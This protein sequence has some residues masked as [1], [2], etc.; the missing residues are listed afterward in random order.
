MAV[1]L[2][3]IERRG[4]ERLNHLNPV[5]LEQAYERWVRP[6][7]A[8]VASVALRLADHMVRAGPARTW[9]ALIDLADWWLPCWDDDTRLVF[10]PRLGGRLGT[11]SGAELD[12]GGRLWGHVTELEP[13]RRRSR[14]T[15]AWACRGRSPGSGG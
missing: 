10:E 15:A 1:E 14:W 11:T 6:A 7:A 8:N 3:T 12:S 5:P 4:R 13:P 2:V 9:R